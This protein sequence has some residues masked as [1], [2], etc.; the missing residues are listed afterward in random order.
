MQPP[1]PQPQPGNDARQMA[2]G[3]QAEYG[4]RAL[5]GAKA[6]LQFATRNG[7]SGAIELLSEVC[8]LLATRVH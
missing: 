4:D 3:L 1:P 6:A 7:D 8:A 5:T 2:E